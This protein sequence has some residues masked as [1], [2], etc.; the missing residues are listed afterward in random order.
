MSIRFLRLL[1]F[2][3]REKGKKAGFKESRVRGFPTSLYE[4]LQDKQVKERKIPDRINKIYMIKFFV[5]G[6]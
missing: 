3:F 5:K 4:L 6:N 1:L 2:I